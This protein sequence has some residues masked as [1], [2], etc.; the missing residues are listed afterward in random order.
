MSIRNKIGSLCS[1]WF[2]KLY[3]RLLNQSIREQNNNHRG[4]REKED[5]DNIDF[6]N[7]GD[8]QWFLKRVF[9]PILLVTSQGYAEMRTTTIEADCARYDGNK[10]YLTGKVTIQNVL[11]SAR[12]GK[13]VLTKDETGQAK[14]DF[15]FLEISDGVIAELSDGKNLKCSKVKCD[16]MALKS[17]FEG[18]PE[19]YFQDERGE[20]YAHEADVTY[21]EKEGIIEIASIHLYGN[22]KMQKPEAQFAIADEVEYFPKEDK[23]ILKSH[24]G[25]HV[26]F[27][28]AVKKMQL[29]ANEV[30]AK[31]EG[32]NGK[33]SIQGI[34]DV[35]FVL[36]Q[37]EL[38]KLKNRFHWE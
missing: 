32:E 25:K 11:G 7:K 20:I 10:I 35:A 34:G 21:Q 9:L 27:Y 31:K 4:H 23:I 6:R 24:E 26:I 30:I 37:E 8:S 17:H 38:D 15:P 12:A 36:K 3:K 13:A 1:L 2:L 14:I 19:L 22:V 18:D 16:Y 29:S 28:D 5:E 33:E